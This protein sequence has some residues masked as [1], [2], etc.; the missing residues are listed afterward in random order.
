MCTDAFWI[1]LGFIKANQVVSKLFRL[2]EA[3]FTGLET[4]YKELLHFALSHRL[5]VC[6]LAAGLLAGS[7][8]LVPLVGTELMPQSD[9]GEVRVDMEME[10]GTRVAVTDRAMRQIDFGSPN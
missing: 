1:I 10:V 5:L 3:A 7:L 4:S 6:L 8:A 2:S 9:E